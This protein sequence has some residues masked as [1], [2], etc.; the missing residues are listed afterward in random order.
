[1]TQVNYNYSNSKIFDLFK[2][3]SIED[4]ILSLTALSLY[5][6]NIIFSSSLL[7]LYLCFFSFEAN[8]FA[9]YKKIISYADFKIFCE[10]LSKVTPIFPMID[11]YAPVP[12]WGEVVYYNDKVKYR[13]L[14]GQTLNDPISHIDAYIISYSKDQDAMKELSFV[15]SYQ[16]WIISNLSQIGAYSN[17]DHK[18]F[19]IP[20]ERFWVNSDKL[21]KLKPEV[22]PEKESFASNKEVAKQL[23]DLNRFQ[24]E[25]LEGFTFPRYI[26]ELNARFYPI[27][28]RR[29]FQ[30]LFDKW[31]LKNKTSLK[32]VNKLRLF[33]E[34]S[35]VRLLNFVTTRFGDEKILPLTTSFNVSENKPFGIM[36]NFGYLHKENGIFYKFYLSEPPIKKSS[37]EKYLL[38]LI[39]DINDSDRLFLDNGIV[40]S[41]YNS[42]S[43]L[44][45]NNVGET[46]TI[47]IVPY[48]TTEIAG[49]KGETNINIDYI[50]I[51]DFLGLVDEASSIDDL[52]DFFIYKDKIKDQLPPEYFYDNI[53]LY[54]LF[55]GTS[56]VLTMGAVDPNV[57]MLDPSEGSYYRFESLKKFWENCFK[58]N[59][60]LDHPRSFELKDVEKPGFCFL[61]KKDR[62][63]Y[64]SLVVNDLQINLLSPFE[65]ITNNNQVLKTSILVFQFIEDYLNRFYSNLKKLE[66]DNRYSIFTILLLPN[67]IVLNNDKFKHLTKLLPDKEELWKIDGG[68][69]EESK[70]VVRIVFNEELLKEKLTEQVDRKTENGLFKEILKYINKISKY[71]NHS[72]N[73]LKQINSEEHLKPRYT[74]SRLVKKVSFPQDDVYYIKPDNH[75]YKTA[76]REISKIVSELGVKPG[77]YNKSDAKEIINQIIRVVV[78]NL[79]LKINEYSFEISILTLIENLDTLHNSNFFNRK[80]VLYSLNHEVDYNREERV[81]EDGDEFT[82][83][84][85]NYSYTIEK[86]CQLSPKGLKGISKPE[87]KYLLAFVDWLN[88]LYAH[89]NSLHHDIFAIKLLIKDSFETELILPKSVLEN[90]TL[91]ANETSK[92]ILSGLGDEIAAGDLDR[93]KETAE[94]LDVAFESSLGFSFTYLYNVLKC[95]SQWGNIL[96]IGDKLY[97]ASERNDLAKKL[98]ELLIGSDLLKIQLILDFLILNEQPFELN[99]IYND[100]PVNEHKHRPR[101]YSI[102]PLV[103]INEMVYWGSFSAS[104]ACDIWSIHADEG[105][106]PVDPELLDGKNNGPIKFFLKAL[107]ERIDKELERKAHEIV[108]S[109]TNN[110]LLNVKKGFGL[111]DN[112]EIGEYDVLAYLENENIIISV[113]CKNINPPYSLQ[114]ATKIKTEIFGNPESHKL[115]KR[116]GYLGKVEARH[117]Y[118]EQNKQQV[119]AGFNWQTD[120]FKIDT[121]KVISIY[122]SKYQ[123]WWTRFPIRET[124]VIFLKIEELK[125]F[126]S[127]A[128]K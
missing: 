29:H 109:F 60:F 6:P 14:Y 8:K 115:K 68:I 75:H 18:D 44:I 107:H 108:K 95:L 86:F 47:V 4:V 9:T 111:E 33:R 13:I 125:D 82:D 87:L 116:K 96:E 72:K 71:S 67:Y 12:D 42:A 5:L 61:S 84:Y 127:K 56:G 77:I 15:L 19:I 37:F 128:L 17:Y 98:C 28:P 114:E 21:T 99:T 81:K 76:K 121:V 26:F 40:T 104:K 51:V 22:L 65:E 73:L 78:K 2:Q 102:K 89:A 83:I 88:V 80:Q 124:K 38:D 105:R 101:R 103:L 16:D 90:Q 23:L 110:A 120:Q 36:Y 74:F 79:E 52:I 49:F 119:L 43:Y 117:L 85:K 41:H 35:D 100:L 32:D 57:L 24:K 31:G 45:K 30:V 69:V 66:I 93:V 58:Y 112:P 20:D 94:G 11:D 50:S 62:K 46:K 1:M 63:F 10:E 39:A 54:S 91:Y 7:Y 97:F 3:Y 55:K 106:L 53:G 27:L 59:T 48:L 126:I 92:Y 25:C 70:Y 118:L 122:L 34:N 123:N 113:E 64:Y